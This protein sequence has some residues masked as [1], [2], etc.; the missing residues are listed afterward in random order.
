MSIE[1]VPS[2]LS[3]LTCTTLTINQTQSFITFRTLCAEVDIKD[4]AAQDSHKFG[5]GLTFE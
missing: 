2:Y 3:I 1:S 4:L 5:V